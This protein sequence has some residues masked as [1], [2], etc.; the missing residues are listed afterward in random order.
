MQSYL[1]PQDDSLSMRTSGSWVVEKLDY[2]KRYID[3][4]ATSMHDKPWRARNY[5]DL[6][7]GPG[8]CYVS[9]TGTVHL[10]SPLLALTTRYPFTSYFFVDLNASN[11][12]TLRQ[13]CQ[14]SPMH[15][16]AQCF[17]GDSNL[18]VEDIV[19]R[20]WA[21]D[22]VY[23]P[24]QWSSLN[25]AFLDPDGLQLQWETVATL[26]R[27]PRMDLIIHYPQMGLTRNMPKDCRAEKQTKIDLFFGGTEW[28]VIYEEYQRKEEHF[29]HRQLMDHYKEK[30]LD[31]GYKE[32]FRDDEVGDEPLIRNAKKNVPLYRLLF[33][34]KHPLGHS[35]WRK[36][37]YRDVH[38][39]AHLL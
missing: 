28:R 17:V 23:I 5:I 38:G 25:L 36:V 11:I 7:T 34:S 4:F 29:I 2:L 15:D 21:I 27:L 13:R 1:Q 33:T 32:V 16:R 39:Q 9:E 6:F 22:S 26:A 14:A 18:V 24:G 20:I 8:K 37:T 31:M 19:E 12:A 35:F 30:L 3:I 10:G